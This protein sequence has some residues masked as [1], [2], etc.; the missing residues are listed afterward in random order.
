VS[1]YLATVSCCERKIRL[2]RNKKLLIIDKEFS[3]VLYL[4]SSVV[5]SDPDPALQVNPDPGF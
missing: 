4:G 2:K 1:T 5:D 3:Y